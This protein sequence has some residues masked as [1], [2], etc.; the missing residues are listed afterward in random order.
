MFSEL[1]S[2]VMILHIK[3]NQR[4]IMSSSQ[5]LN[6]SQN[7]KRETYPIQESVVQN[8]WAID[9]LILATLQQQK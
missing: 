2:S 5:D 3:D 1:K 9:Q 8:F 6:L 4:W 7:V